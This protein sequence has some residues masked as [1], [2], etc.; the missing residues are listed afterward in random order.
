MLIVTILTAPS[1][2]LRQTLKLFRAESLIN[3]FIK[4]H[5]SCQN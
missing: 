4:S 2:L 3:Q 1:A 5:Q